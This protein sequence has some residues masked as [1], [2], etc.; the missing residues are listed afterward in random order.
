LPVG[1]LIDVHPG[2]ARGFSQSFR[3]SRLDTRLD[4]P[5]SINCRHPD[6]RLAHRQVATLLCRYHPH[7]ALGIERGE[8]A[9]DGVDDV[10]RCRYT[11]ISIT[12]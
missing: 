12:M 2:T 9:L 7:H 6:S 8:P 3:L 5:P 10:P 1:R 4:T 11:A